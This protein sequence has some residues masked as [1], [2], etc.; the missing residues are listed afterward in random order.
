MNEAA[1]YLHA[2]L[3]TA[4]KH[5]TDLGLMTEADIREKILQGN[6]TKGE[7]QQG[8][9]E[10]AKRSVL[11][12]YYQDTCPHCQTKALV[13]EDDPEM[14]KDLHRLSR[15]GHQCVECKHVFK[16]AM[17]VEK[18]YAIPQSIL[19]SVNHGEGRDM[20]F[21]GRFKRMLPWTSNA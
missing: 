21:W 13:L 4:T 5:L 9:Y 17:P 2:K 16:F 18:L 6:F 14:D 11:D 15:E 3:L 7:T 20:S 8:I 12:L 10:C 19:S 1:M